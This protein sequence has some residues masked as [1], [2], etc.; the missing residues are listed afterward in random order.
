MLH[1][2]V[3]AATDS[4][5][6]LFLRRLRWFTVA[7]LAP[8]LV[9]LFAIGQ[10]ASVKRSV[11]DMADLGFKN[12]SI[13]HAFYADSGGFMLQARDSPPFPVT[14]KQIHYLVQKEYMHV[15]GITRKEIW[16]KSKGICSREARLFA[17]L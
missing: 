9:M 15:P 13:V 1:L 8:E 12:W 6:K 5:L 4:D 2:N 17:L 11:T 7:L 14:A 3:P 10:W 16:D